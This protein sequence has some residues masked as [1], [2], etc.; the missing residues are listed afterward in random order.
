SLRV[1]PCGPLARGTRL[2]RGGIEPIAHRHVEL[3]D[4]RGALEGERG[5]GHRRVSDGGHPQNETRHAFF[6]AS[7]TSLIADSGTLIS[8][9]AFTPIVKTSASAVCMM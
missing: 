5:R 8:T 7:R 4:Q 2:R 3:G 1:E 9:P 6:S